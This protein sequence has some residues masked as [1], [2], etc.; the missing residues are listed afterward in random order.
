MSL[1]LLTQ[2]EGNQI[3][4]N[5]DHI[6]LVAPSKL[7][8]ATGLLLVNGMQ[9]EIQGGFEEISAKLEGKDVVSS[10]LVV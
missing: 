3:R 1:V 2:P 5:T 9:L 4:L 8:G 7:I 10:S 6:I